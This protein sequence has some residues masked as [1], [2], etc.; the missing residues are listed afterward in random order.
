MESEPG[1]GWQ[2]KKG[3]SDHSRDHAHSPSRSHGVAINTLPHEIVVEILSRLPMP[4]LFRAHKF[5]PPFSV[6]MPE[7]DLVGLSKGLL[8]LVNAL[9]NDNVY[10]LG[11]HRRNREMVFGF[12]FDETEKD[13]KV[14]KIGYAIK[15]H[16]GRPDR[17]RLDSS[18][19]R[20]YSLRSPMRRRLSNSTHDL[21]ATPLQPLVLINRRL[22]WTTSRSRRWNIRIISFDLF[23]EQFKN[24]PIPECVDL[25]RGS[26]H[27]VELG[28]YLSAAILSLSG[29]LEIRVMKE[30]GMKDSWIKDYRIG[31]YLPKGLP[32]HEQE[33]TN[34]PSCKFSRIL[35]S[36][37]Y[38]LYVRVLGMLR[39]GD[40]LLEYHNRALVRYDPNCDKAVDLMLEGLPKWFDSIVHVSSINNMCVTIY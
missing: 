16:N 2:S 25:L 14:I 24:V 34:E 4:T 8:C 17:V 9:Y 21:E 12:G 5:H 36:K 3:R 32:N 37:R 11:V 35:I 18:E 28:G 31:S 33:E 38:G 15:N 39:N 10:I 22:H 20:V 6:V 27:L 29:A 19:V 40:I 23:D 13:Y 7:F 26:Y 30:Y 1:S